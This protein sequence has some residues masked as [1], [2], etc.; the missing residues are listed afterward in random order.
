MKRKQHLGGIARFLGNALEGAET[1]RQPTFYPASPTDLSTQSVDECDGL[2]RS[3][4][5]NHV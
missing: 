4:Q 1:R 5:A 3:F 2:E